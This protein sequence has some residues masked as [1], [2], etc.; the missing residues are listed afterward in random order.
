MLVTYLG[1]SGF[2]VETGAAYYLFDYIRG[3]L[4]EFAGEKPLY[5]FASHVHGDHF[6][7]MIFEAG[8]QKRVE[9]YILSSDILE[10]QDSETQKREWMQNEET[11]AK[12]VWI[13][14]GEDISLQEFSVKAIHSTDIGVAFL[15]HEKNGTCIYH[16]GDLNWWHWDGEPDPWNPDMEKAYKKEINALADEVVDIAFVPVDPRLEYAYSYGLS[17]FLEKVQAKHVF[18]MHFWGDYE[19]IP[20]YLKEHPVSDEKNTT[21]HLIQKED[22]SYEI[23]NGS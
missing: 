20:R 19:I 6:S 18:P 13:S 5:V 17:Y 8:L 1:H 11:I 12:I 2:L 21:I 16:A 22:E 7:E 10:A 4:P 23:C 14:E 9:K 3:N 15:L